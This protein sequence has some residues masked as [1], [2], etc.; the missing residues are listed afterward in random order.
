MENV[1]PGDMRIFFRHN[2]TNILDLPFFAKSFKVYYLNLQG[3][4]LA[5][6]LKYFEF[7]PSQ[8]NKF[9]VFSCHDSCDP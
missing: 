8:N 4:Y 9:N 3:V 7:Y 6:G 2:Q 1:S 5:G